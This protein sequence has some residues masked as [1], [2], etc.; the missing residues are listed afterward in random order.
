MKMNDLVVGQG[1]SLPMIDRRSVSAHSKTLDVAQN[2]SAFDSE[3]R[4]IANWRRKA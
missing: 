2:M 3:T 4:N 1:I